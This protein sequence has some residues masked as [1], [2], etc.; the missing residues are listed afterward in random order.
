MLNSLPVEVS[1]RIS[2]IPRSLWFYIKQFL[3]IW[4]WKV[5]HSRWSWPY[6]VGHKMFFLQFQ[7]RWPTWENAALTW[8]GGEDAELRLKSPEWAT[9]DPC[10]WLRLAPE[11]AVF[12]PHTSAT[13]TGGTQL[14]SWWE[15]TSV[16][17]HRH[18]RND[19]IS[20][21]CKR[22][23]LY[24]ADEPILSL[25]RLYNAYDLLTRS[26]QPKIRIVSNG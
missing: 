5:C 11:G 25:D 10:S 8:A 12:D 13:I 4:E 22:E 2:N 26:G 6:I 7:L 21:R 14:C 1:T 24:I 9:T 15:R 20:S 3:S 23:H 18:R 19:F 17:S 16:Q